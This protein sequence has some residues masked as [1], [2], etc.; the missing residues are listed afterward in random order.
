M[1]AIYTGGVDQYNNRLVTYLLDT[2][3]TVSDL[4]TAQDGKGIGKAVAGCTAVA[5]DGKIYLYFDAAGWKE[6]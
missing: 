1:K 5:T 6:M 2:G 4:P 3:D